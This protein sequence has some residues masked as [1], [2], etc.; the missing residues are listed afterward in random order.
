MKKYILLS[1]LIVLTGASLSARAAEKEPVDYVSTLVGTASTMELSNGNTYPAMCLPYAMNTWGPQTGTNKDN[2]QYQY[3][4]NFIYG[5]RQSRQPSLWVG[6]YGQFS[7]MP[8]ISRANFT[9]EARRSWHSHKEETATPYYYSGYMGDAH[10]RVEMTPTERAAMFRFHFHEAD[11]SFVVIDAFDGGSKVE[12][13]PEL[14]IVR[15]YSTKNRGGV[16]D[17][18]RNYFVFKFNKPF[19]NT[20]VWQGDKMSTRAIGTTGDHSGAVVGFKLAKGEALIAEVS[21]SFISPEQAMVNLGEIGGRT[22][23]EVKD[24]AREIWNNEL[25]RIRVE[26]GTEEQMRTFYSCLYRTMIFP[27]KFYEISASGDPIHYSPFDGKVHAGYMF[28]DNG[29]WDTFRAQLPLITLLQPSLSSQILQGIENVYKES[30]W[31][32][33]WLSPGH[34]D[35]MIGSH[36]AAVIADAYLKGIRGFDINKLYE[37]IIKNTTAAGPVSSV[38]RTGYEEYNRLGYI[39]HD[40]GINQN[41]SRTLE[42]AYDDYAIYE[43]SKAL[44]RP[45]KESETFLRRSLNYRN[46]FDPQTRLMRPRGKDGKFQPGFDPFRW[47]D[48]FTEANS[49]QYSWAVMHDPQGLATLMGGREELALKLDSIFTLPPIFDISYYKRGVIHLVRE[50]QGADMGQYAHNNEPMH[51]VAYLYTYCR[52]PWKTQYHVREVMNRLYNSHPDGYCGDEDNGQM[53]AWYVFSALGMYPVCPGSGQYVLGAPLFKKATI[54]LENGKKIIINAPENSAETRYIG[55]MTVG[56]RPYG[57]NY[58]DHSVLEGGTV[59]NIIMDSTP[60]KSRGMSLEA[61]PYSVSSEFDKAKRR[62]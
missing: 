42:Y 38:G 3:E 47:G 4:K 29:F 5:F 41:V 28:T 56:G 53:S 15:G 57:F 13:L 12:I 27:R 45:K 31:L 39:P 9:E 44:G 40:T 43:L 50:M 2:F 1:A 24:D 19:L 46:L 25:G 30:G 26:G 14:G 37:G 11:S 17:N 18:F 20:A 8:V 7:I 34:R 23:E 10:T 22:F 35:C 59:I 33:E 49:W 60:N 32:P 52:Q 48:H 58:I 54:T 51:H 62:R 36:S 21:S 16:P 55:G 61:A 6:D